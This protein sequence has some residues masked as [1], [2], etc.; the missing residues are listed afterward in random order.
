MAYSRGK[1]S[2]NAQT[3][4]RLFADSG[5]FC[6]NPDCNAN[7]FLS[8]GDTDFHIAEMAHVFCASDKGPRMNSRLSAEERGCYSN[9][10]LL[11]PTCHTKIDKAENEYPDTLIFDWK[12]NHVNKIKNLFGVKTFSSRECVRTFI[13]RFLGENRT[14][15]ETYGPMTDERFNPESIMPKLWMRKIYTSILPNNR[16]IMNTINANY[17]LLNEMEMK[18]VEIFRQHVSDFENKHINNSEENGIKFP[19]E[20]NNIFK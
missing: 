13:I 12:T 6:Q 8:I 4:L 19:A 15:F 18:V 9:L 10:I 2:P 14:I 17:S 20:I 1:A 16:V 11:C 5:G 7:L 3:K